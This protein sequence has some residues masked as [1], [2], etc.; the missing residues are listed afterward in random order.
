M[1]P[2]K[3]KNIS[4]EH[5]KKICRLCDS[6]H[7]QNGAYLEFKSKPGRQV[8]ICKLCI[9]KGDSQIVKHNVREG[10]LKPWDFVTGGSK[11]ACI[12]RCPNSRRDACTSYA[13]ATK[14]QEKVLKLMELMTRVQTPLN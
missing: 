6:T 8:W 3:G 7:C 12:F 14:L 4:F 2:K 1:N 11:H 9:D 13:E 10:N 5:H